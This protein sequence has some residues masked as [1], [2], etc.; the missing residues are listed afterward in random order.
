MDHSSDQRFGLL[1][2]AEVAL[3]P[4]AGLALAAWLFPT[5]PFTTSAYP[6]LWLIPFLL[7]LRYGL[8]PG[9]LATL[10]LTVA[11]ITAHR[12]GLTGQAPPLIQ[13][14]GGALAALSAGQYSS[15]WREQLRAGRART[16]Y[17]EQRLESLT[18]A[19]FVTRLSHDRLEEALITQPVTLR[20]ALE[21]L[22]EL[23]AETLTGIG[24]SGANAL[25]QLLAQYCRFETAA[26]HLYRN[27]RLANEP[28]AA[29]GAPATLVRT[30]PLLRYALEHEQTAY[31]SIDQL[32]ELEQGGSYRAVFPLI[33][34]AREELGV[35]VV[36]DLPLLALAEEN[37][38]AATAM[39]QYFADESWAAAQTAELRRILPD[40]PAVFAH[41]LIKLQR[42][43]ERSGVRSTLIVVRAR[44][45]GA[46]ASALDAAHAARRDLDLYW[47]EP[48]GPLAAGMLILL[49]LAGP[50]TAR[51][52]LER[53]DGVLRAHRMEGGLEAAGFDVVQVPI[54]HRTPLALLRE[55]GIEGDLQLP[56]A[57]LRERG[58]GLTP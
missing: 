5:A 49:P 35:L 42:L 45:E 26:L 27:G 3:L 53:I 17:T 41:E 58:I 29:L 25:L 31:H 13:L 12:L 6:W 14:A 54:D 56:L 33:N 20:G 18:R 22:R 21:A 47:R 2:W 11:G 52:F 32:T 24:E 37:L 38:T 30:D 39:L 34:S 9:A 19:F 16:D 23:S 57:F 15:R 50:A 43:H 10:V 7:G 44:S 28:L 4:L 1:V 51:G 8:S 36:R 46:Q 48:F 55:S 40:C